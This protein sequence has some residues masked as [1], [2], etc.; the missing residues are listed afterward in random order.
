MSSSCACQKCQETM[1]QLRLP[2]IPF[3]CDISCRKTPN[4]KES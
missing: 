4:S 1:R 2:P 3:P